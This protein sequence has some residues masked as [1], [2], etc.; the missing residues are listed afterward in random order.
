MSG[1]QQPVAVSVSIGQQGGGAAGLSGVG[2]EAGASGVAVL[3]GGKRV[4]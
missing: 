4:W 3:T 2:G 1:G